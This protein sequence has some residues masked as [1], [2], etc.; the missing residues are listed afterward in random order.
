M[1]ARQA[2]EPLSRRG[3]DGR[4][5]RARPWS[6]DLNSSMLLEFTSDPRQGGHFPDDMVYK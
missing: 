2:G 3:V 6:P 4:S 1:P 5:E